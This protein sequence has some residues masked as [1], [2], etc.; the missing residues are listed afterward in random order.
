M[1]MNQ[2]LI[3]NL[4]QVSTFFSIYMLESSTNHSFCTYFHI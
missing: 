1:R 2:I 3:Q 4:F